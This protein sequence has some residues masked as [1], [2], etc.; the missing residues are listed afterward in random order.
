MRTSTWSR[1]RSLSAP[2]PC[3]SRL[4]TE[5]IHAGD[6]VY[7]RSK[8]YRDQL[9]LP[10]APALIIEIKR[11]N[12]KVLYANDKRC[13]LPRDAIVRVRGE[14]GPTDF[15]SKLHYVLKRVRAHEC[16]LVS[17]DGIHR[18][19][20][21]IDKIDQTTI[22]DLRRFLGDAFIS[23]VVVPEGMAFM[24]VEITFRTD[25]QPPIPSAVM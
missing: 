1:F 20:A 16:E 12:F 9:Q 21:R 3:D 19:A 14:T 13:W 17:G 10:E 5:P 18:V 8:Y 6:F 22:D 2:R 11:N 23:L 4:K 25:L 7:C 24:Q 15:L